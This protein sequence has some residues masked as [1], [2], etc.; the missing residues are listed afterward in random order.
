MADDLR[1]ARDAD[2]V[3]EA[4]TVAGG[5]ESRVDAGGDGEDRAGHAA[6][7]QQVLHAFAGRDDLVAKVAILG[8]ELDRDALERRGIERDVVGVALV[9]G[10]VGE[11]DRHPHFPGLA[12]GG[13]A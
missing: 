5:E 3:A 11:D 2:L 7:D 1:V 10:V 12:Q 9:K 6:F 13:V 8:G 4:C